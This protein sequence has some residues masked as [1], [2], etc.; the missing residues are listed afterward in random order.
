MFICI[1]EPIVWDLTCNNEHKIL[2]GWIKAAVG[3]K[4][5]GTFNICLSIISLLSISK[6]S[7]SGL[8]TEMEYLLRNRSCIPEG[9]SFPSF[10]H[11]GQAR[12]L[13]LVSGSCNIKK[14]TMCFH[15]LI[16]SLQ[17]STAEQEFSLEMNLRRK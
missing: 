13:D 10:R 5:E 6:S 17:R 7:Y 8:H 16:S 11:Q 14:I 9:E 3:Y 4:H 15:F 12:N 2:V 1:Q